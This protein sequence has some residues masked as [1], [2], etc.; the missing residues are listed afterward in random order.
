V[1]HI[2]GLCSTGE[3]I[4]GGAGCERVSEIHPSAVAVILKEK[5]ILNPLL[6][7]LINGI[8][9][10]KPVELHLFSTDTC[11]C[12]HLLFPYSLYNRKNI[13]K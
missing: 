13:I 8:N 3:L 10:S 11:V 7:N 2:D 5:L 6:R 1:L 9:M 12:S 4:A